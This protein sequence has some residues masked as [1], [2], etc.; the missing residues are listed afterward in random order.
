VRSPSH[1]ER[2]SSRT[3]CICASLYTPTY[4]SLSSVNTI[5]S[6]QVSKCLP[7]LA[8]LSRLWRSP[9]AV[10]HACQRIRAR[11][12]PIVRRTYHHTTQQNCSFHMV[13]IEIGCIASI[14]QFDYVGTSFYTR[15][16]DASSSFPSPIHSS[17]HL[18]RLALSY[19]KHERGGAPWSQPSPAA[20][21]R[22]CRW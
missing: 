21:R 5:H 13:I 12:S 22:T 14:N 7:P 15:I 3:L 17:S 4:P 1:G 2:L 11:S 9:P 19:R 8:R 18:R 16:E 6:L 10:Q 20:T